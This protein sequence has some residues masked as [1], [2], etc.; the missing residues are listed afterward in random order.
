M[1]LE[2]GLLIAVLSI[3]W[4][5]GSSQT[6]R[7]VMETPVKRMFDRYVSTNGSIDKYDGWRIQF[8]STTDRRNMENTI[9]RLKK[10][11]PDVKFTWIYNEP[12]YQIR[13]GAFLRRSDA[14]PLQFELKNE[15]PGAFPVADKIENIEL[16][17]SF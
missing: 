11:Y 9:R 17:E 6:A 8:Y 15:F 16:L 3:C 4:I 13:A 5:V 12:F 7:V 2:K 1:V 10:Q 14:L